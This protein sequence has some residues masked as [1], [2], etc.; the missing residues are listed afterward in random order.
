NLVGV[1]HSIAA[2]LPGMLK[3]R[4][5]HLVALSS[6]ASFRGL[7]R[8]LAY[9]ASKAGLN[10]LMEG[11]RTEVKPYGLHVT[12][13]CPGWMRTPMTAPLHDRLTT[14]LEL[15]VAVARMVRA[16]ERKR[17][18]YAFPPSLAW[19]LRVLNWL[20]RSWQDKLLA[21]MGRRMPPR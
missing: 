12:T 20:P 13:I 17:A 4:R 14:M 9:S 18:F 2:V 6:C 15:D 7:P 5:G 11:L 8:L 21:H 19:R 16:I 1:A 3:R 10:A